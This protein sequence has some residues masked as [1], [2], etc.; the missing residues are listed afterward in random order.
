M[1]TGFET[2]F[3]DMHSNVHHEHIPDL[4]SWYGHARKVLDFWAVAYYPFHVRDERG[5]PVEDLYP[6]DVIQGDWTRLRDFLALN[7]DSDF[8]V[9]HGYEWQG[10]GL[11]GDH[12][13][14]FKENGPIIH[15]LRYGEL[16]DNFSG[17][18]ALAI[19][20]HLA[21][22]LGH[23]GK[24]WETHDDSFSPCAEIYSSHGSSESGYSDLPMGRH[25]HMGPR[26]GGTSVFDGLMKGR[27]FGIIASG[28]NHVVPGTFGYGY[29]AVLAENK[30]RD[31]LWE[32]F[33]RRRVYGV[34]AN[35]ILLDY[36]VNDYC[37]GEEVKKTS[38]SLE[39]RVSVVAGD[40]V[41][42]IELI[43]NN[44]PVQTYV[45]N[46]MWEDKPLP[47]IVR[48]KFKLEMGWGPNISIF[49]DH[50]QKI[51]RGCVSTAGTILSVENCFASPGQ[52]VRRESDGMISFE[53]TTRKSTQ[54]GKW[55]GP[56][57][58]QTEGVILEIEAPL[59][60]EVIFNIDGRKI[61]RSVRDILA[62]THLVVFYDEAKK[63]LKD[64]CG[65][66]DFY[67]SDPFYHNAYKARILR[68]TPESG[69]S[70]NCCFE[71]QAKE[72][73]RYFMV[74]AYQRNGELAWSSPVFVQ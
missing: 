43:R 11:D 54:S 57:P 60:S 34:S 33:K 8:P 65:L 62:D 72:D 47:N 41:T 21:Y 63:L 69:Y 15:P 56:S 66:D 46:G 16:L 27:K 1:G 2:Y 45:H 14:F 7:N 12:N 20:H 67:R 26:G 48:F 19:P 22:A 38:K 23:R 13:L 61:T 70:V 44:V 28:D 31:S 53:L 73:D 36:T 24:N 35:K 40:A 52:D 6:E 51:W 50:I 30:K 71:T 37:M 68:G 59:A 42:R 64:F 5:M 58:V 55:M 9:F 3:T 10:A 25:I 29:A 32:A 18:D 17:Q 39:H 49:K 74:K 4:A